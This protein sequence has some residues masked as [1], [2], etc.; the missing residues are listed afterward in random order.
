M[1]LPP[2]QR[3]IYDK[4][5]LAEVICQLR[6]PTILTIATHPPSEFQERIRDPYV[7]Y[8]TGGGSTIPK[9]L[10]ELLP[11]LALQQISGERNTHQFLTADSKRVISLTQEFIA[12]SERHYTHWNSFR[13]ELERAEEAVRSIYKPAFYTRIGLRYR[14]LINRT[15][16]GLGDYAWDKL[17]N[18]AVAGLIAADAV[19]GDLLHLQSEA[20]LQV[21]EVDG[22]RVRIQHGLVDDSADASKS[23]LIDSDLFV[24]GS[25]SH[26]D[27]LSILDK[28]HSIAGSLFRWAI[29]PELARALG[30]RHNVDAIKQ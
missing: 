25:Y 12:V 17:I 20:L 14:N 27:A 3:V 30:Q 29:Q 9:E 10:A 16:L 19:K 1:H 8:N 18:P 4:N 7:L 15:V 21:D 28:L 13:S 2:T 6:F 5:P 23:Y 22:G 24:E 26:D 11:A